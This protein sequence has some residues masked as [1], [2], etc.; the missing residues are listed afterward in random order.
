[1]NILHISPHYGGGIA[2]AVLGI[3][4]ATKATHTLVEIVETKDIVSLKL[5]RQF[6]V[7]PQP[8]SL[9]LG[10]QKNSIIAD[11]VIFHYWDTEVWSKLVD[12]DGTFVNGGL[13]LLNHRAINFNGQQA[14]YIGH[15]FQSCVQSGFIDQALPQ[16]W[17]LIPTCYGEEYT[18]TPKTL[19]KQKAVYIGTLAYK[20]VASDYF[21]LATKL[22]SCNISLDI[23]GK[24]ID[25]TFLKHT[26]EHQRNSLKFCGYAVDKL[27]IL[28]ECSYFFYPLNGKHYGTTENALLE[29]M[30]A[31]TLPLV[32]DNATERKI[33]GDDLIGYLDID[34][35]LTP[36][37]SVLFNDSE[38]RRNLSERIRSRALKL[39]SVNLRI[40]GWQSVLSQRSNTLNSVK[41]SF[42][43]Q[44][45]IDGISKFPSAR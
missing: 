17:T 7:Q 36:E 43:A 39:I 21:D 2:P 19:R 41:L 29:G 15:I 13:V 4:E 40:A 8:I 31:G 26:K 1:M 23:Y 18:A 33:V 45:I 38:L 32:R 22:V 27:P 30:L 9:L 34:H 10:K 35:C 14:T 44:R 42:I 16:N 11:F 6:N 24:Q 5:L 20:K 3:I 28:S 12:L 37:G 25:P